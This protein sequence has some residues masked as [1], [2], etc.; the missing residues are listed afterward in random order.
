MCALCVLCGRCVRA[1]VRQN[2]LS[3]IRAG[4]HKPALRWCSLEADVLTPVAHV[5]KP[6][7]HEDVELRTNLSPVRNGGANSG[8]Y[9]L[10]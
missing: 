1:R 7:L 3:R 4:K 6:Q 2:A 9:Q 8:P 5:A 10:P